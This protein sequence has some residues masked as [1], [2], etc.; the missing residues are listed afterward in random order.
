MI[1]PRSRTKKY[2]DLNEARA[3]ARSLFKTKSPPGEGWKTIRL[4]CAVGDRRNLPSSG[5]S[6]AIDRYFPRR[7]CETARAGPFPADHEVPRSLFGGR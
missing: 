6:A 5:Q 1:L 4:A 3:V 2:S 7:L